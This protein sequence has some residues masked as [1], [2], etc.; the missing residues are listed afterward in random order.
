M[1]ALR[2]TAHRDPVGPQHHLRGGRQAGHGVPGRPDQR[3]PRARPTSP[4]SKRNGLL[5]RAAHRRARRPSPG[6]ATS[7]CATWSASTARPGRV[8]VDDRVPLGSTVRFHL[9]DADDRPPRPRAAPARPSGRRPPW[10]SP[11]TAGAPGCS[12][13]ADHDAGA[14][15]R[16]LGPVPVGGFFAAGEL[17]PVGGPNFV[18]RFTASMALFRDR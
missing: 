15:E 14:V 10:C 11:A 16:A 5:R 18:H 3:R 12:T 9:R 8:A 2:T 1:P 13:T 4:A 7:W 17:G 6:P